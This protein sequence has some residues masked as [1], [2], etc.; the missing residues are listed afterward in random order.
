MTPWSS[1]GAVLPRLTRYGG[2][3]RCPTRCTASTACRSSLPY[4]SPSKIWFAGRPNCH[5]SGTGSCGPRRSGRSG[6]PDF[7]LLAT[8]DWPHYDVVLA[9]LGEE[10]IERL[11]HCFGP[12]FPNPGAGAKLEGP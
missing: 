7:D 6:R 1:S 2:P 5:R 9:D 3:P 11:G 10:T 8:G 12:P 4:G